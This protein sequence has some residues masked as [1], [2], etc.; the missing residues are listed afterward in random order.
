M[1]LMVAI[2]LLSL[3]LYQA[4]ETY[5]G[6]IDKRKAGEF[7]DM[8]FVVIVCSAAYYYFE[9]IARTCFI[10]A[11]DHYDSDPHHLNSRTPPMPSL[12]SNSNYFLTL[13]SSP[14]HCIYVFANA[15]TLV[16]AL[17]DSELCQEAWNQLKYAFCLAYNQATRDLSLT[18]V[19]D[20]DSES[21]T[22][23]P[24]CS[25][26]QAVA[27]RSDSYTIQRLR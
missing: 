7:N 24:T 15:E 1:N 11:R 27:L 9:L 12:L 5:Y 21:P 13:R 19:V 22:S 8:K 6:Q 14:S 25:R 2:S 3:S 4:L 17:D 26:P 18:Q 20:I 10:S 16:D 23:M